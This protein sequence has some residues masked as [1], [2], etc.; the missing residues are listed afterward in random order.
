MS[1]RSPAQAVGPSKLPVLAAYFLIKIDVVFSSFFE[2][3]FN[4]FWDAF[5]ISK[6][7]QN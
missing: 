4:D 2:L 5:W 6:L 3:L 1:F 7:L